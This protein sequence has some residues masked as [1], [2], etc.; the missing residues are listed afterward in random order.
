MSK[1][2][3]DERRYQVLLRSSK[4]YMTGATRPKRRRLEEVRFGGEMSPQ[5][6]DNK[7]IGLEWAPVF[8]RLR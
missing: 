1:T 6:E 4:E 3:N 8:V 7:K 5:E 2:P